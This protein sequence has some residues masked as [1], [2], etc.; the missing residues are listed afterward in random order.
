MAPA[1]GA[2][3]Q[4]GAASARSHFS[5]S[6]CLSARIQSLHNIRKLLAGCLQ[7]NDDV[8]F[9][10]HLRVHYQGNRKRQ[11]IHVHGSALAS[12]QR[13]AFQ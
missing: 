1:G 2:G 10:S 6:P 4:L 12:Y 13:L 8:T 5:R 3:S 9:S 11:T 7:S